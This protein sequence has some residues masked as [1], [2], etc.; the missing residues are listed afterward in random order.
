MGCGF[1]TQSFCNELALKFSSSIALVLFQQVQ[2][3]R[4]KI[5]RQKSNHFGLLEW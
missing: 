2:R 4:L 5:V 1:S 3:Q